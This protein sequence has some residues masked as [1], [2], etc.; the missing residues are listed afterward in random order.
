MFFVNY[1]FSSPSPF[2]YFPVV[3]YDISDVVPD[4]VYL[5]FI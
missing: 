4:K 3:K 1:S 2:L 5:K